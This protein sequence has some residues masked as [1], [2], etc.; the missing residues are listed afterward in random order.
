M[1]WVAVG[2]VVGLMVSVAGAAEKINVLIIDG[3]HNH[4]WAETTPAIKKILTDTGRFNVDVATTPTNKDPKEAWAKLKP[5]FAKYGVVVINYHGQAWP[6]EVNQAFETYMENGGGMVFY[7]AA[8]FSFP[9]WKKWNEAMALGWRKNDYGD[10]ITIDN[11]GKVLRTPKGEGP[12]GGHG[13]AHAFEMTNRLPDHPIMKGMPAKWMRTVKDELYHGQR[14]PGQNMTILATAFSDQS[15]AV[16]GT[17]TNEPMAWTTPWGKGRVFATL[18][19]HDLACTT[20]ADSAA[21]LA[22]GCE[23]AATGEVTVAGMK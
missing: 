1:R 8:L 17:G 22:R 7:H 16:K 14:G 3:Q 23:W 10:R 12:G 5:E 19:G 20:A 2:L 9:E 18:L 15:D 21:I 13:P 6:D 11:D 4:K